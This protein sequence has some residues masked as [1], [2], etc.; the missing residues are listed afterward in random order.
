MNRL[1]K[2]VEELSAQFREVTSIETEI[3][4]AA[5]ENK[6]SLVEKCILREQA[7]V[8]KLR[9]LEREKNEAQSACGFANMTFHQILNALDE[10]ERKEYLPIFEE[11]SREVQV[12][13]EIHEDAG[14]LLNVKLR[15]LNNI[16]QSQV[17]HKA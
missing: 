11:L 2:V 10:K 7:A 3:M 15:H 5:A 8:M 14:Q 17:N 6:I 9:G 13:Q 1:G 4:E 16:S 12:F